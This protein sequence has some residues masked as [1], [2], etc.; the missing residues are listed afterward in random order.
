[1]GPVGGRRA[2]DITTAATTRAA[3]PPAGPSSAGSRQEFIPPAAGIAALVPLTGVPL[4]P[5]PTAEVAVP[6]LTLPDDGADWTEWGGVVLLAMAVS[7]AAV[8]V[9][10]PGDVPPGPRRA[11]REGGLA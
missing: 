6:A 5:T 4:E 3:A 2:E 10:R 11:R 1:A 7:A 8:A 9:D